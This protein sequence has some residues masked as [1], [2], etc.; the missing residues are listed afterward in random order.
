[1]LRR[2]FVSLG[3]AT[4]AVCAP[5]MGTTYAASPSPANG[6]NDITFVI[7]GARSADASGNT[8][9]QYSF[10]EKITGTFSGIRVGTGTL[11]LHPDGT[12]NT[13]GSG[14]F[15]GTVNGSAPGTLVERSELSGTFAG[16]TGHYED[17]MGTGGLS[18]IHSQGNIA[19][20]AVGPA[21]FVSTYSGQ[22]EFAGH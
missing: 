16:A 19:G 6:T 5:A 22:V 9:L 2:A 1:M 18:G 15:T 17:T 13:R 21:E 12:L 7:T 14:I 11:I 10:V 8:I 20:A 4:A 3:I